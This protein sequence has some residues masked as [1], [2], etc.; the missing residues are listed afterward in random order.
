MPHE[1]P[2]KLDASHHSG[3]SPS[4]ENRLRQ[5]LDT[6]VCGKSVDGPKVMVLLHRLNNDAVTVNA[7]H[8]V[9]VETTPD[10]LITLSTGEKMLVRDTT[11]DVI[12]KV[13]EY[14]RSLNRGPMLVAS[15]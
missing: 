15:P 10:T 14:L 13:V 9:T 5:R 2:H 11:E 1:M 4:A 7:A 3:I 8:I 6:Q 12:K